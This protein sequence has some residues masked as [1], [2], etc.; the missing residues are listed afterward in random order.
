[1]IG[2]TFGRFFRVT[3]CG[4]SYGIGKGSGLAVIVDGVPPGIKITD[5]MIQKEMDKRRPG[6]GDL[7]SPRKETDQVHIFAGIGPDKVTSGVP[8][9]MI[10]YNV[11]TQKVHIDQYHDYKDLIRPGHAEY[12][13][14][15]KYGE[16]ADW[17]GAGRASG[18]ETVGRVA[19]GAIA[20]ILLARENIEVIAYTKECMGIRA[21]EMSFE[22]VKKNY[23]KNEINCPDLEAAKKM[24][25]KVLEVKKEG[26]TAGGIIELIIHNIP[27]GIGEPVFDKFHAVL[28]HGIMSIGAVKGI[29]IGAGFKCGRMKGSE[30]NDHPYLEKDKI[31]FRTNNAGGVLGGITTGEDIVVRVAVKPTPTVSVEQPSIN[32]RTMK[33]EKLSPI[34]RRDATLLG[35]IYAVIEAMAAISTVDALFIDRGWEGMTKLNKKWIDLKRK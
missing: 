3:T 6:M 23:R 29:E 12:T 26:D 31:R 34:T 1:M 13:F 33:E 5:E 10:V 15:L 19:A 14:F 4:E 24:I 32:M 20:K 17:C 28:S 18:R 9:G 30:F 25:K 11:D 8:I 21:R 27:A 7:N 16:F 35:R 22:E 2:N